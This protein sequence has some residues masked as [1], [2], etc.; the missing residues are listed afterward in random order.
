MRGTRATSSGPPQGGGAYLRRR[1]R[2]TFCVGYPR[3]WVTRLPR[4]LA[5]HR[6][7]S[8]STLENNRRARELAPPRRGVGTAWA[9][10]GALGNL[11]SPAPPSAW[12]HHLSLSGPQL[13]LLSS[14][15]WASDPAAPPYPI[16]I[17]HTCLSTSV[18]AHSGQPQSGCPWSLS[19][20]WLEGSLS[21]PGTVSLPPLLD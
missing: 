17:L 6:G 4:P 13:T 21:D 2:L 20:V 14:H 3:R 9:E 19:S 5:L 16:P 8:A 12:T 15:S 7:A 10:L 18:P 1:E 11:S